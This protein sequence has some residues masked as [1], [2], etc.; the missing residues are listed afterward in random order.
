M[1]T[2]YVLQLQENKFYVGITKRSINERLSDH[3]QKQGSAWT[4]KYP[5]IKLLESVNDA[6]SF[7][8][9][10]Y[11]KMY[12]LKYGVDNVRGGSYLKME[13]PQHQI[14]S[15]NEEF[16][17]S[18]NKCFKCNQSGHFMK[19][20]PL[21]KTGSKPGD[22][23][24]TQCNDLNFA[25]RQQCR[26]CNHNRHDDQSTLKVERQTSDTTQLAPIDRMT[27]PVQPRNFHTPKKGDWNCSCGELNFASRINCRKCNHTKSRENGEMHIKFVDWHCSCGELNFASRTN[28]HK[29]NLKRS[30]KIW[31]CTCGESN[32]KIECSK[33][34]TI[35]I[36]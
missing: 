26:K 2:L 1:T 17:T 24:C 21:Y 32:I 9:D 7:T 8:E 6:D 10:K 31:I 4:K 22:W 27:N 19:E 3:V 5:V 16:N 28:C 12:M 20:C 14:D 25:S 18:Q 34:K 11:V 15:L 36:Q 30:D 29:C 13:L 35:N 33:C 23:Y